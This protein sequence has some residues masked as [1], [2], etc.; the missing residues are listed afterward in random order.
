MAAPQEVRVADGNGL[1]RESKAFLDENSSLKW[2]PQRL[3][4]TGGNAL[5]LLIW[6]GPQTMIDRRY[7]QSQAKYFLMVPSNKPSG[8]SG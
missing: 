2:L 4:A 5:Q 6:L 3:W 8:V 7:V 1:T